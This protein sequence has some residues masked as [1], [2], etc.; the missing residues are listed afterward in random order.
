[1]FSNKYAEPFK[2]RQ[3]YQLEAD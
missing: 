3:L 1:M 2:Q